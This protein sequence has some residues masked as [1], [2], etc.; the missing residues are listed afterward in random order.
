MLDAI[1]EIIEMTKDDEI[2]DRKTELAVMKLIEIIG[3]AARHISPELK[4][5]YPNIPWSNIIG[6]RNILIHEYFRISKSHLLDTVFHRVPTIRDWV[7]GI[8]E[9]L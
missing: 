3:E 8:L 1:S 4:A 7:K 6:M 5:K 9:K 2:I